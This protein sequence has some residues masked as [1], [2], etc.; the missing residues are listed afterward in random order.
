M[1]VGRAGALGHARREERRDPY[2]GRGARW[3]HRRAGH[4]HR[5]RD[6]RATCASS[7]PG[8]AG[9]SAGSRRAIAPARRG[10]RMWCGAARSRRRRERPTPRYD[11]DGVR[12]RRRD[13]AMAKVL[14][15]TESGLLP[16]GETGHA[17]GRGFR[18]G[19][20]RRSKRWVFRSAGSRSARGRRPFRSRRGD[21]PVTGSDMRRSAT[22]TS[23][24]PI[25]PGHSRRHL[26]REVRRVA[27]SPPRGNRRWRRAA[28]LCKGRQAPIPRCSTSSAGVSQTVAKTATRSATY[29][30]SPSVTDR[31]TADGV[32][33]RAVPAGHRRQPKT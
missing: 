18:H 6:G 9:R 15:A 25:W 3:Q 23:R 20:A 24:Q 33:F 30:W 19:A 12:E 8:H 11:A 26:R 32:P 28:L 7:P 2:C 13:A 27:R 14:R 17:S 1:A 16:A 10:W 5:H 4:R 31:Q 22:S 21:E 29:R